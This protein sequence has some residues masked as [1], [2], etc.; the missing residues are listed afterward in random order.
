MPRKLLLNKIQS[1]SNVKCGLFIYCDLKVS[2]FKLRE[3]HEEKEIKTYI[4]LQ[5]YI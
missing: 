5:E 1:L 4:G 2:F 3:I